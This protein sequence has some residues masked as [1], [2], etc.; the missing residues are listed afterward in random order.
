M[1]SSFRA[2]IVVELREGGDNPFHQFASGAVI[3]GLGGG[4]ESNTQ[5]LKLQPEQRV[6]V[7]VTG[8]T[9]NSVHNNTVN[10]A[11]LFATIGKQIFEFRSVCSLRGLALLNKDV[12][13]CPTL[14]AAK[15]VAS[16][17]LSFQAKVLDLVLR[18]NATID[19][20]TQEVVAWVELD[21]F[22]AFQGN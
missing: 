2:Y 5:S 15:L 13:H 9:T 20:D 18:R 14:P 1:H 8:K 4:T 16:L 11:F 7:L 21:Y 10:T 12:V 3:D 19:D 6:V 17:L 22:T